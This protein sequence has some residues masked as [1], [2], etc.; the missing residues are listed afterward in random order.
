MRVLVLEDQEGLGEHLEGH[1]LEGVPP[2]E[3]DSGE[4]LKGFQIRYIASLLEV[5]MNHQEKPQVKPAHRVQL[6][7]NC[8]FMAAGERESGF[9]SRMWPGRLLRL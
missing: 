4:T 7:L 6:H 3:A 5:L 1:T 9:S 8:Q 2:Q